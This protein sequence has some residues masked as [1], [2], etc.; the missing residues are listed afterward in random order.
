MRERELTI[1]TYLAIHE[2]KL[3][4]FTLQLIESKACNKETFI[5]LKQPLTAERFNMTPEE[6]LFANFFNSEKSFVKDMDDISL[7]EH[8]EEL[9]LIAFEARARLT[10]ADE[11]SRGR[12]SKRSLGFSKSVQTDELTSDAISAIT[13]RSIKLSKR[14]KMIK[15]LM[16]KVGVDRATAEAMVP[17]TERMSKGRSEVS[18]TKLAANISTPTAPIPTINLEPAKKAVNPFSK[19]ADNGSDKVGD[20]EIAINQDTNTVII[21]ETVKED[22]PTFKNPFAK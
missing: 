5:R 15:N 11:E 18:N 21:K 9:R 8:R 16:D 17:D 10:A 4:E 7:R 1:Q 20:T 19:I 12:K 22:K 14:E 3:G 6:Q 13:E 2:G